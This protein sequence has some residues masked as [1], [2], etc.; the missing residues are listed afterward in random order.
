MIWSENQNE[1]R[2]YFHGSYGIWWWVDGFEFTVFI[3]LDYD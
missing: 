3:Q 1:S 2:V